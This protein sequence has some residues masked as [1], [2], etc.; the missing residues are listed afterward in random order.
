LPHLAT[1]ERKAHRLPC[2]C[3][4]NAA[5]CGVAAFLIVILLATTQALS[6]TSQPASSFDE[7]TVARPVTQPAVAQSKT[8]AA[9]DWQRLVLAMSIVLGLIFLLKF[10]AGKAFPSLAA[11]K[12]SRVVRVLARSPLAPKQQLVLVQVGRRVIVIGDSAGELTSLSEITDADEVAS[13]V[14]QLE[15]A[16]TVVSPAKPFARLFGRARDEYADAAAEEELPRRPMSDA[17]VDGA[18]VPPNPELEQT[19]TE[20]SGLIQRMRSLSET[21]RR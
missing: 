18:D 5:A 1:A 15:N 4:A 16:E 11:G 6:Q 9:F 21:M 8:A 17:A 3:G 7:K 12:G 19:Q 2:S 13:L 14:G 10:L 20:I